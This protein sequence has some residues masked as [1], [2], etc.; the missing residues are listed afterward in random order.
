MK[1]FML[2]FIIIIYCISCRK[3]TEPISSFDWNLQ[4][5]N[6]DDIKYYAIHFRNEN[7]GWIVGYSGTIKTTSDGGDSWN[8]QPSGVQ[9]NL[10]DVCF[11]NNQIGWVCGDSNTILYTINGGNSWER[12]TP[13]ESN[14]KIYL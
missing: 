3:S 1:L 10:W 6:N 4:Y 7:P 8:A 12:I 14:G 13:F 2:S 9:S 11:I 5:E